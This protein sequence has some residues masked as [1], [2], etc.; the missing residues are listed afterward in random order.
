MDTGNLCLFLC[1][2]LRGSRELILAAPIFIR[3][4]SP[5]DIPSRH[6]PINDDHLYPIIDLVKDSV[7]PHTNPVTVSCG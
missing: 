3:C 5:I 1:P 4:L 2:F 6:H 7:V